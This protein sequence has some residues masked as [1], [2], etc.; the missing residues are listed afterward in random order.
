MNK[1]SSGGFGLWVSWLN[2]YMWFSYMF[3]CFL[4]QTL[5]KSLIAVHFLSSPD[6]WKHQTHTSGKV[7][8]GNNTRGEGQDRVWPLKNLPPGCGELQT[9]PQDHQ[10]HQGWSYLPGEYSISQEGWGAVFITHAFTGLVTLCPGS[11]RCFHSSSSSGFVPHQLIC[12][13]DSSSSVGCC[14]NS[15]VYVYVCYW[16]MGNAGARTLFSQ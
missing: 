10:D 16:L 8:Q 3:D 15:R 1:W 6:I 9:H 4:S 2:E 13:R 5:T 11:Q 14:W 12:T 7:Q